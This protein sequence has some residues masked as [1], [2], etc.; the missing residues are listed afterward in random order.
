MKVDALNEIEK[1]VG[2]EY[3][4]H[5]SFIEKTETFLSDFNAKQE[6]HVNDIVSFD[7]EMN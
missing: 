1:A 5:K 6:P 4:D 3:L 7:E 2:Y